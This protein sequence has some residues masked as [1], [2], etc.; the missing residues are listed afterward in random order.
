M[1]EIKDNEKEIVVL[2]HPNDSDD[3]CCMILQKK[4]NYDSKDNVNHVMSKIHKNT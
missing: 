3:I 1:K 2:D 4:Q